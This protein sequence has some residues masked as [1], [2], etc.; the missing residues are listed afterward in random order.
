[1][2]IFDNG[3]KVVNLSITVL[4]EPVADIRTLF[5]TLDKELSGDF[6]TPGLVFP[7]GESVD[8]NIPRLKYDSTH[9]HSTLHI[10]NVSANLITRI[11]GEY[12]TDFSKIQL[13]CQKR[14]SVLEKVLSKNAINI[15]WIGFQ[16]KM[17]K[18]LG[19]PKSDDHTPVNSIKEK[20]LKSEALTGK[21]TPIQEA[22]YKIAFIE[23]DKYFLN[24]HLSNYR[25][26]SK[27]FKA[28]K[29]Q[30]ITFINPSLR[31][32]DF[33]EQGIDLTLDINSKYAF[34]TIKDYAHAGGNFDEVLS[35]AKD[36]MENN[37]G[38]IKW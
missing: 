26:Y 17:Q 1:M 7:V 31:E 14:E 8:P 13:Y 36:Y 27:V 23:K 2:K 15:K 34:D 5:P 32:F 38:D 22:S 11:D 16:L 6:K 24:L 4:F 35:L 29:G 21:S 3:F 25:G 18:T 19:T 9:G 30:V 28:E 20:F 33:V 12:M 37:L 10:S